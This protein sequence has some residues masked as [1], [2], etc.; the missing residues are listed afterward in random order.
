VVVAYLVEV[1]NLDEVSTRF[2]GRLRQIFLPAAKHDIQ[3]LTSGVAFAAG[4][5]LVHG[6][7]PTRFATS[8]AWR[9][10]LT[11]D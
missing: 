11:D 3:A 4:E 6:A 1:E 10:Q 8:S 5:K 9:Q 7:T 2:F